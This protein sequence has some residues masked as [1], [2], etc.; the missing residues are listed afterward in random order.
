MGTL[1]GRRQCLPLQIHFGLKYHFKCSFNETP[2]HHWCQWTLMIQ[3]QKTLPG[4]SHQTTIAGSETA[5]GGAICGLPL[6]S[7]TGTSSSLQRPPEECDKSWDRHRC[8]PPSCSAPPLRHAH[9][10]QHCYKPENMRHNRSW[11][12]SLEILEVCL[13]Y[14][15]RYDGTAIKPENL[16]ARQYKSRKTSHVPLWIETHVLGRNVPIFNIKKCAANIT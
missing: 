16:F 15:T 3:G 10:V 8:I 12:G 2:S 14:H 7:H 6:I 13:I 9:T 1:F 5:P 11:P 4:A